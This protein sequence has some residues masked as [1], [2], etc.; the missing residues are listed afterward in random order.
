MKAGHLKHVKKKHRVYM[1]T[2][3]SCIEEQFSQPGPL[4]TGSLLDECAAAWAPI[5]KGYLGYVGDVNTEEESIRLVLEMCG[6]TIKPGDLGPRKCSVGMRIEPGGGRTPITE[7]Y[8]ERLL[9]VR[10]ELSRPRPREQEAAARSVK[11]ANMSRRRRLTAELLKEEGNTLFKEGKSAEAASKYRQAALVYGPRPVYMSN[12]AAALLKMGRHAEAESAASRALF[13]EPKNIKARYRRGM[14]SKGLKSYALAIEDF[15]SVLRQDPSSHVA[16]SA[17]E[18]TLLLNHGRVPPEGDPKRSEE[19][20]PLWEIMT[21]S[22]SSEYE[23]DGNG[24]PCRYLNHDGCRHGSKCRWKHAPDTRS[25]RDEIGR[26]VCMMWLLGHCTYNKCYYAHDKTYLP[27]GGWW[28]K[29]NV[30]T[31]LWNDADDVII[32]GHKKTDRAMFLA[33]IWTLQIWRTDGWTFGR[34]SALD[35]EKITIGKRSGVLSVNTTQRDGQFQYS[36]SM[37]EETTASV[38]RGGDEDNDGDDEDKDYDGSEW[39]EEE[40]EQR[41]DNMG[42]TND[43]LN[44]I[45][46]YG[47]K[48]W[49]DDAWD[50]LDAVR[51]M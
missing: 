28:N 19:H 37:P 43:E 17:L 30:V 32:T 14:A 46:S 12:L 24:T 40:Q 13:Y 31:E 20:D 33:T 2:T 1:P 16:R 22:D 4:V 47:V 3:A 15:R 38:A 35:D 27:A 39:D 8:G 6:I 23:H 41:M 44:D 7:T 18:E 45:L 36:Y 5:G 26:N 9:P 21:E 25:V 34:F 42:F 49:D 51:G 29:P 50:V 48:P 10:K 11:R